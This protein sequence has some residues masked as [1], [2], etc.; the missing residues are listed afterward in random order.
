MKAPS[1]GP[2]EGQVGLFAYFSPLNWLHFHFQFPQE[3]LSFDRF[4]G[5]IGGTSSPSNWTVE[6]GY[7][8]LLLLADGLGWGLWGCWFSIEMSWQSASFYFLEGVEFAHTSPQIWGDLFSA[9][10]AAFM[11]SCHHHFFKLCTIH[12]YLTIAAAKVLAH[13]LFIPHSET[14][15][16]LSRSSARIGLPKRYCLF[17]ECFV[18]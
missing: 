9:L 14:P 17:Q 5:C 6:L 2:E 7:D 3:F 8:F 11:K 15:G 18:F 10:I 13:A 1:R 16:C 12:R 4:V